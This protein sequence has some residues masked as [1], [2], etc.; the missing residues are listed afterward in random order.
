MQLR[1]ADL[2]DQRSRLQALERERLNGQRELTLLRGELSRMPLEQSKQIAE[3]RRSISSSNQE[4]T[5]SELRRRIFVL[6]PR[7]GVRATLWAGG[8]RGSSTGRP[9]RGRVARLE[10]M[11]SNVR[12]VPDAA[13]RVPRVPTRTRACAETRASRRGRRRASWAGASRTSP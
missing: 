11:P 12:P 1:A 5:E 10:A 13:P 6:A 8:A 3:I 9:F 2:I 7:D 4:L